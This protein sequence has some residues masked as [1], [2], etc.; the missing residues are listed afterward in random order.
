MCYTSITKSVYVRKITDN[1]LLLLRYNVRMHLSVIVHPNNRRPRIEEDLTGTLHVYVSAP[2]LEG[3][4]N[5]AVIEALAQHF[6]V[7]KN[8]VILLSGHTAKIK[9]FDIAGFVTERARR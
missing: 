7:G 4:A 2:P 6:K 1:C 5:M 3:R 8:K 9:R